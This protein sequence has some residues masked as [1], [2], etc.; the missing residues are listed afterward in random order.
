MFSVAAGPD[1][2]AKHPD[3]VRCAPFIILNK[4]DLVSVVPF[5]TDM[6]RSTVRR[7]NPEARVLE[8]ST[9]TG[10]GVD[11]WIEWLLRSSPRA[12]CDGDGLR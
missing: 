8:M 1:K 9:L 12:K 6:F 7:L 4:L 2:P 5:D 10:E 3:V 11:G